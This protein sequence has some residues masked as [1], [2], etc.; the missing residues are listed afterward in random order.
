MKVTSITTIE[1]LKENKTLTSLSLYSLNSE[2]ENEIEAALKVNRVRKSIL[3]LKRL[4]S[5][6]F[7]LADVQ[8]ALVIDIATMAFPKFI[9]L[10]QLDNSDPDR[11][12]TSS[13]EL[14]DISRLQILVKCMMMDIQV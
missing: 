14:D 12:E 10:A 11:F 9:L 5:F 2:T 1:A 3:S 7:P 6:C 8:T 13:W 4:M